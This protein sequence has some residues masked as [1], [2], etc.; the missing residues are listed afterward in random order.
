MKGQRNQYDEVS[1][2]LTQTEEAQSQDWHND[3]IEL[4]LSPLLLFHT[5][6]SDEL[7]LFCSMASVRGTLCHIGLF[8]VG[9]RHISR[10]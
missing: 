3:K 9:T 1:D 6:V 8:K 2:D 5:E 4:A 7:L 10:E